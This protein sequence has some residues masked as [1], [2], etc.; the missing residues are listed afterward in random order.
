MEKSEEWLVRGMS[1][2]NPAALEAIMDLYASN[3]YG[4]VHRILQGA[5]SREDIEECVSDVFAAWNRDRT[6]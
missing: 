5:V 2:Q 4:L 6:I 3:I 1:K